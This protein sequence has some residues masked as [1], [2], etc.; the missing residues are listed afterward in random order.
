MY[1]FVSQVPS[2]GQIKSILSWCKKTICNNYQWHLDT[3]V[4]DEESAD[5]PSV[6]RLWYL[7]CTRQFVESFQMCKK[8]KICHESFWKESQSNPMTYIL[9][10]TSECK[11]QTRLHTIFV[12]LFLIFAWV[13]GCAEGFVNKRWVQSQVELLLFSFTNVCMKSTYLK[14]GVVS[15]SSQMANFILVFWLLCGFVADCCVVLLHS[16]QATSVSTSSG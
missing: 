5:V 8:T 12:T 7:P 4:L 6:W 16:H 11:L 14:Q 2:T 15:T 10:G 1:W 13:C 3:S 9:S